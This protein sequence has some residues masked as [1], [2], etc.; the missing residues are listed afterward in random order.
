MFSMFIN[1]IPLLGH[2]LDHNIN[3]ERKPNFVLTYQVLVEQQLVHS[4]GLLN[5]IFDKKI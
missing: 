1:N 3:F 2:H 5:S 4:N